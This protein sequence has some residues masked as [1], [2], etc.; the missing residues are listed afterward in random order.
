MSE[1][2]TERNKLEQLTSGIDSRLTETRAANA[3]IATP[4]RAATAPAGGSN[5]PLLFPLQLLGQPTR[6]HHQHAIT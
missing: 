6:E 5:H 4:I 1:T 2:Q 3:T